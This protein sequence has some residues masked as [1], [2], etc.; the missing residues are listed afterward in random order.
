MSTQQSS[1][2][3][4][5]LP[6]PKTHQLRPTFSGAAS[7]Q[8]DPFAEREAID[9]LHDWV[10]GPSRMMVLS[11]PPGSGKSSLVGLLRAIA[12][13]AGVNLLERDQFPPLPVT[14][15][16][17]SPREQLRMA[18]QEVLDDESKRLVIATEIRLDE[19]SP[20][21]AEIDYLKSL[22][23][24]PWVAVL[25]PTP[26]AGLISYAEA[27][28]WQELEKVAEFLHELETRT[29]HDT[30]LLRTFGALRVLLIVVPGSGTDTSGNLADII[31]AFVR[32]RLYRMKPPSRV[33]PMVQEQLLGAVCCDHFMG[34]AG[35]HEGL[36]SVEDIERRLPGVPGFPNLTAAEFITECPFISPSASDM[37][38]PGIDKHYVA[39]PDRLTYEYFVAVGFL[40]ALRRHD[41]VPDTRPLLELLFDGLVMLF[42]QGQIDTPHFDQLVSE[43]L[44]DGLPQERRMINLY[45]LEDHPRLIELLNRAPAEYKEWLDGLVEAPDEDPQIVNTFC[46]KMAAYQLILLGRPLLGRFLERL[47]SERAGERAF[48]NQIQSALRPKNIATQLLKRLASDLLAPVRPI[49]AVRLGEF[50]DSQCIVPLVTAAL[51]AKPEYQE[52]YLAAVQQL[53]S[54]GL[55]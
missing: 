15:E 9:Y 24:K 55:K 39:L 45:L 16:Q 30:W 48:E 33:D 29:S 51:E 42:I 36:T 13:E 44:L 34:D 3:D 28:E 21:L 37:Q 10:K 1:F 49:T 4:H 17:S 8:Q 7:A 31:E 50:G 2:E 43:C 27:E 52:T 47:K 14:H 54:R 40:D 32:Q 53:V 20:Y 18:V 22:D 12:L 23:L 46:W 5:R 41:P 25:E 38:E 19:N 6:W 11:G 26:T 35:P